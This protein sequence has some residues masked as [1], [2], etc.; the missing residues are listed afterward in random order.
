MRRDQVGDPGEGHGA[1]HEVVLV[2]AVGVAL[3]VGVVLVD[4]DGLA[5]GQDRPHRRHG[6]AQHLL[7]RLVEEHHLEG[8]GAL[9]GRELGVGVVDVVAGPVGQHGVH[10]VGLHLGGQRSLP[11]E[12]AG[13]VA[14]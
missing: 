6:A 13:V 14:R 11:G 7:P 3:A 5:L 10:E 8:V 2:G 12:A 4:D 1:V 9:G